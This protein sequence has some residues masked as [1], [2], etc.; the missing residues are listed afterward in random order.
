M[1][2]EKEKA[3]AAMPLHEWQRIQAEARAREW[4]EEYCDPILEQDSIDYE[5]RYSEW[6]RRMTSSLADL[7]LNVQEEV[8]AEGHDAIYWLGEAFKARELAGKRKNAVDLRNAEVKRVV[9]EAFATIPALKTATGFLATRDEI[10]R[11]LGLEK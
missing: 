7:I 11:R 4:V 8:K 6:L 2:S 9:E 5:H 1:A 3:E 10:L